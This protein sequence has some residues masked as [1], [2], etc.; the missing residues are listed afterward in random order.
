MPE[1]SKWLQP[2][3][4]HAFRCIGAQCEDTCCAGWIVHVDQ[5]TYE[6]YQRV[7]APELAP[8]L[9]QLVTL[10]TEDSSADNYARISLSGPS[11]PFLAEGLCSIQSRLGE[12]Y[13]PVMCS[14][15]PRV[16]NLVD[17]TLQ[18]SLDLSC[19][20][21]ARLVLLDPEPMRFDTDEGA[22]HDPR[23]RN[24]SRLRTADGQGG[25]PYEHFRQIREVT[26]WMLQYRQYGLWERITILASLCDQ[27]QTNV[28]AGQQSQIPEVLAAYRDA[29]ERGT[30]DA[31]L[32]S[33]RPQQVKQLELILELIIGR[34]GSDF[35]TP[36][37][38]A[39][40]Q[41]FMDGM[42]WTADVSMAELG[43]RYGAAHAQYY[44]P[45]LKEHQ[46][47]LEH[48][49]VNYVHRTLFP[50]G[51]QETTRGPSRY[52]VART[53][54]DHCLLL[55]TYFGIIQTLLVGVASFHKEGF[56]TAEALQVI[57]SFTKAFE[58]S[59]SFPDRA[60]EIQAAKGVTSCIM[61]AILLLN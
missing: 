24:L 28:E 57:Q 56:G 58:H 6:A 5:T 41:K 48:Y 26:I 27:L 18:R 7:D 33:H 35:T 40:Y 10:N 19:P 3:S 23:R 1:P 44:A 21:A 37:L 2:R 61:M 42:A 52:Y 4:Y 25:K 29:V 34:I 49:L 36:R 47:M 54:R 51:P 12:E 20:E 9:H 8:R 15:Y 17:D 39:C 53:I 31:A 55:L 16:M 60:K 13:L 43:T 45:F 32:A 22:P 46:H 50:L 38:L 11:C 59:P 30:F 14:T